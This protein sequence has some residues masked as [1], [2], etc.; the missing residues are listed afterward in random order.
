MIHLL[1]I[2]H[3][4][5]LLASRRRETYWTRCAMG[6][7]VGLVLF[8]LLST[9]NQPPGRISP[10]IFMVLKGLTF[11]YC[12]LAGVRY[13]A[14]ALSAERRE[15]TLGLLF[16]T[17]LRGYDVVLGK[18]V[19]TSLNS[20]FGLLAAIPLLSVPVMMGGVS[21]GELWR[22]ILLLLNTLC[23]SLA[24][25]LVVSAYGY[26]ERN[27]MMGTLFA[28][29]LAGFGSPWWWQN[30]PVIAPR[31][32][33]WILLFPSPVY[34]FKTTVSGLFV[35]VPSDFWPCMITI[36]C[37]SL[38][39]V[40]TACLRLPRS[41][42]EA[43]PPAKSAPAARADVLW[44]RRFVRRLLQ[45]GLPYYW[46]VSRDQ[47]MGQWCLVLAF[48]MGLFTVYSVIV[49]D[50]R[51]GPEPEVVFGWLIAHWLIKLMLTIEACRPFS[52]DKRSGTLELLLCTPLSPMAMIDAQ[53]KRL[54]RI[55]IVPMIVAC[56]ANLFLSGVVRDDLFSTIFL[57][58]IFT[59][60]A[61]GMALRWTSMSCSLTQPT[62]TRAVVATI[63][64]VMGP[65][66][67]VFWISVLML[68]AGSARESTLVSFLMTWTLGTVVYDV[69][70][71]LQRQMSLVVSFRRIAAGDHPAR[72]RPP[73]H[74][75]PLP[76]QAGPVLRQS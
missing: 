57:M 3:R 40:V 42:Q 11:A 28:L 71:A 50:G 43:G 16:L 53:R 68:A 14:D 10:M 67:I 24:V 38:G 55:F 9:T 34:A 47:S 22:T 33:E 21:G 49:S 69:W 36:A 56:L 51:G 44:E 7:L 39:C 41:F 25:G 26:H 23:F 63:W 27:V 32:V 64:R 62:Y 17:D 12:L 13:T 60:L 61:D 70:L 19:I 45:R 31:W 5:L 75:A 65:P 1:P 8:S 59:L 4:E 18:L 15:G 35:T 29:L 37:L 58:G 76:P 46:R 2:V 48:V 66:W 54:R 72:F 6:A 30:L 73:A 20:F 52:E 74:W